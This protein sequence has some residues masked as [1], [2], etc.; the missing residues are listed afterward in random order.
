MQKKVLEDKA[1]KEQEDAALEQATQMEEEGVVSEVVDL[2]LESAH[3]PVQVEKPTGP[4]LSSSNSR[5]ADWDIE[6]IDKILVPNHYKTVNEGAIR[7]AVR[8]AKGNIKVPGVKII[9]TFKTRRKAL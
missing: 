5:T 4:E 6:I 2:V 3:D 9:D 7:A 8:A 1:R